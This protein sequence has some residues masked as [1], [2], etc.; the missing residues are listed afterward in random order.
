MREYLKLQTKNVSHLCAATYILKY[1]N[2]NAAQ[3]AK[4]AMSNNTSPWVFSISTVGNLSCTNKSLN[5]IGDAIAADTLQTVP[6][7]EKSFC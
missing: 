2:I 7:T 1:T 6:M 4:N 5:N 3:G